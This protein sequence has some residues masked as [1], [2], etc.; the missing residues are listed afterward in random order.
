MI[1]FY[2]RDKECS[3]KSHV[4]LGAMTA[5]TWNNLDGSCIERTQNCVV[6]VERGGFARKAGYARDKGVLSR[7]GKA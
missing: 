2:T 5:L 7:A 1:P 4:T 6:V 3:G